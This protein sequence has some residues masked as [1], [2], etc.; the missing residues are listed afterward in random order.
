M[1]KA[2]NPQKKEEQ[3]IIFEPDRPTIRN[4]PNPEGWNFPT[5]LYDDCI[6]KLR[7]GNKESQET[8][9]IP[10]EGESFPMNRVVFKYT[11]HKYPSPS[12]WL[13]ESMKS[14]VL[15]WTFNGGLR[16]LIPLGHN[17][18]VYV[19]DTISPAVIPGINLYR[20][21]RGN[22]HCGTVSGAKHSSEELREMNAGNYS[23]YQDANY[24]LCIRKLEEVCEDGTENFILYV[25][26]KPPLPDAKPRAEQD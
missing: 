2:T 19:V 5:K 9:Y 14:D 15:R 13:E 11:I 18:I 21:E 6:M 7:V 23:Y 17:S 25:H 1:S 16:T 8:G 10:Q 20:S 4:Y 24:F 12:T 22:W 3:K 26:K